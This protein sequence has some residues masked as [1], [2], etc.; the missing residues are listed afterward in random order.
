[1][2]QEL[3]AG[4]Q[5]AFRLL[6]SL[7]PPTEVITSATH[8]PCVACGRQKHFTDFKIYNS[9]V[10][11]NVMEPLCKLCTGTY[12]ECSKVVCCKCK[13]VMGWLDPHRDKDG[14]VFEKK[15][16]YHIQ[17][18]PNCTPGLLKADLIEK[19]IYLQRKQKG[20]I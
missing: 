10:V 19:I 7:P 11:N 6:S 2:N 9:G 3:P 5:Q 16:S 4:A 14:F 15:H 20:L 12:V 1:M 13:M 18:C 8:S 17:T